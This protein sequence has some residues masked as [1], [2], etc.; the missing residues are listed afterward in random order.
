[1]TLY[2]G[3]DSR[4]MSE[5]LIYLPMNSDFSDASGNNIAVTNNGAVIV[6][7]MGC[8]DGASYL[9]FPNSSLFAFGTGDFKIKFN[10]KGGTQSNKFFFGARMAIR[11]MYITTGGCDS[12]TPGVL[13]YMG[14][15]AISGTT[16]LTDNNLHTCIIQRI[17]GNISLSVDGT[18]GATGTDPTNYTCIYGTFVIAKHDML[19]GN[20]LTGSL[21]EFEI[22][23]G[24]EP[25]PTGGIK[26]GIP[27]L[28][29]QCLLKIKRPL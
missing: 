25:V 16:V 12:S 19:K 7:G 3:G 10:F 5:R 8:F 27:A 2:E 18:I 15:S 22:W 24:T 20:Y 21:N 11:S 6:D 17:S 23:R 29:C 1:M 9:T 13:R 28:P 26:A 4:F 14:F